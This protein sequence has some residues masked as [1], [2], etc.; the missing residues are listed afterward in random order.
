MGDVTASD[1][2]ARLAA[3]R[4]GHPFLGV[5]T[6]ASS[7]SGSFALEDVGD[8]VSIG[9][10]GSWR[11]WCSTGTTRCR[12]R[13]RPAGARRAWTG[14]C[15]DDGLS[16]NGTYVNGERI[17]GR[18][19]ARRRGQLRHRLHGLDL[20][21]SPSGR[22]PGRDR[23]SPTATAPVSRA[24]GHQ[25]RVLRRA[26]PSVQGRG[27]LRQPA[28]NQ[29]IAEELFLSVDAVKTPPAGAVREVRHRGAAAEPEARPPGRA[30][31][32]TAAR[33]PGATCRCS[34]R[35]PA[36]PGTTSSASSAPG[37]GIS[38]GRRQVRL[39]RPVALKVIERRR[40]RRTRSSASGCGARRRSAGGARPPQRRPA[41]RGGRGGRRPS[42][43]H[44]LDRRDRAGR[45]HPS[46]PP[47]R[48]P[49]TLGAARRTDRVGARGGPREDLLHRNIKPSNV[50]VHGGGPRLP[51]G[52]RAH[53][54]C[55][56]LL[57]LHAVPGRCWAPSST[58]RRADRG[59]RRR[60]AR[61]RVQPAC[62][63]YE[64]LAGFPPFARESGET[65]KMWAHLDAPPPSI[66]EQRPDVPEALE[67]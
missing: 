3:E 19:R 30:R 45:A 54:A 31:L 60:S 1:L 50:M 65:R 9:G 37:A 52:L 16:R 53:Q 11:T 44:A 33:S 42:S 67:R 39:D 17:H 63:L 38:T 35:A 23:R 4:T 28:T 47:D 46:R 57:G 40:G 61:R 41:L 5:R 59:W 26:L 2:Q 25:R 20:L 62:V 13:A 55:R 12:G 10:D 32:R 6:T 27:R 43:S 22:G 64:M 18:R 7:A 48:G 24:V 49:A 21:D 15:V 29:Q 8:Q 34:H 58:W 36:S 66:R 51:H 56:V 14:R